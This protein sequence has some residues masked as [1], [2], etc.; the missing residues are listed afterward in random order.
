MSGAS[1]EF[2]ALRHAHAVQGKTFSTKEL[3]HPDVGALSLAYESFDVRGAPGQ[4]LVMYHAEPGSP[5]AQALA[6][7][8]SL[9]ATRRREQSNRP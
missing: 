8:G 5:G 4:Q 7:L 2:A 9:A 6:L 1:E 3:V